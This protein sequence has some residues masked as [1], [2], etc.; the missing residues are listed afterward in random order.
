MVYVMSSLF[1]G[2]STLL[3][4]AMLM[5]MAEEQ[6]RPAKSPLRPRVRSPDGAAEIELPI[7]G[8]RPD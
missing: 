5:Q 6:K 7:R 3:V 2:I 1:L 4:L 8:R